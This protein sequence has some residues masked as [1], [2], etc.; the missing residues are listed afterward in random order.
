MSKKLTQAEKDAKKTASAT[1]K[2]EK[3]ATADK[4]KADA[5]A[6]RPKLER[7]APPFRKYGTSP[8]GHF[9]DSIAAFQRRMTAMGKRVARWSESLPKTIADLVAPVEKLRAEFET[10]ATANFRPRKGGARRI[11]GYKPGT[12]V[13]LSADALDLL[14]KDFPDLT[15]RHVV[16][17]SR[18]VED[19]DKVVPLHC[20]DATKEGGLGQF[21]GRVTYKWVSPTGATIVD[22]M[23][24]AAET[25]ANSEAA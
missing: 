18:T 25:P 2:A 5:R 13:A 17:V 8:A 4:A 16:F 20:F 24:V 19:G 10:M 12:V 1:A 3:K 14:H 15:D 22:G 21:L 11:L 6:A 23:F 9:A 7:T